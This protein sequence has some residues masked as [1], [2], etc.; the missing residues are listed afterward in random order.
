[1]GRREK[2]YSLFCCRQDLLRKIVCRQKIF[3]VL[4]L[5][6]PD[7]RTKILGCK[8]NCTWTYPL[9]N[10]VEAHWSVCWALGGVERF[11]LRRVSV[12]FCRT[13][14]TSTRFSLHSSCRS[15]TSIFWKSSRTNKICLRETTDDKKLILPQ[16]TQAFAWSR[17]GI[18]WYLRKGVI[19]YSCWW[20]SDLL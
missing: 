2:T 18:Q 1:M 3:E 5:P 10:T 12:G 8:Y 14:K 15:R 13:K 4:I 7:A 6:G 20:S 9:A 11:D 16:L 17:Q 19:V